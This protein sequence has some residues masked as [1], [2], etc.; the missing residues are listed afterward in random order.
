MGDLN[1]KLVTNQKQLND[2]TK[3]LLLDVQAL[4]RMI[5]EDWF[6]D[7]PAR[8]GAEQEICL[9]DQYYKPAPVAI[10]S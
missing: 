6:D 3:R 4:E 5:H 10:V 1:V 2:F 9:V 8:I 7:S